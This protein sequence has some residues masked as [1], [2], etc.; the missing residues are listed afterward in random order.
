MNVWLLR[1]FFFSF[2]SSSFSN[3]DL[4]TPPYLLL[5]IIIHENI[6]NTQKPRIQSKYYMNFDMAIFGAPVIRHRFAIS[7]QNKSAWFKIFRI[8]FRNVW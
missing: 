6:S 7:A 5:V 1:V 4:F 3:D 8:R 2:S